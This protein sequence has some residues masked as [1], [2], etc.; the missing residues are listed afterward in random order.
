MAGYIEQK[1]NGGWAQSWTPEE[2]EVEEE[3]ARNAFR[4]IVTFSTQTG[5]LVSSDIGKAKVEY[6]TKIIMGV[7]PLEEGWSQWLNE[8]DRLG[9]ATWTKEM[10]QVYEKM[11]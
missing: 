11:K 10:N 9:G 2:I 5:E 4:R 7:L 3:S 1:E 8:F 6:F